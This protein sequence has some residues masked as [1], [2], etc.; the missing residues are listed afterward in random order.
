[1]GF[2]DEIH[3]LRVSPNPFHDYVEVEMN[4]G[5]KT[6][7]KLQLYSSDGKLLKTLYDGVADKGSKRFTL[8]ATGMASQVMFLV[9]KTNEELVY[10]KLMKN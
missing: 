8:D 6:R 5:N 7:S 4:I 1:L 9:L 3:S 2:A 10:R